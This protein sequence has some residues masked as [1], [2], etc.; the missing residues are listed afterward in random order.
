MKQKQN[1]MV[2][3]FDI[4]NGMFMPNDEQPKDISELKKMVGWCK[5]HIQ[6]EGKYTFIKVLPDSLSIEKKSNLEFKLV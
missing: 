3:M 1:M 5:E 6:K 2:G 4:E